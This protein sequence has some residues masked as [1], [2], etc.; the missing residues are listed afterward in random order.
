M[1][2]KPFVTHVELPGEVRRGLHGSQIYLSLRPGSPDLLR[3]AI[4]PAEERFR[5]RVAAGELSPGGGDPEV[6]WVGDSDD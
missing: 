1:T 2:F 4:V 6:I 5:L 3:I